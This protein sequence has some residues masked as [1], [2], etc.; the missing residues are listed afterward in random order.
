MKNL[1]IIPLQCEIQ[2]IYEEPFSTGNSNEG[3]VHSLLTC[4]SVN[5][6]N[7]AGHTRKASRIS[8]TAEDNCDKG[9][10]NFYLS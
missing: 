4:S 7:H 1:C 2:K 8:K 5:I 9:V 3:V 6:P 10:G